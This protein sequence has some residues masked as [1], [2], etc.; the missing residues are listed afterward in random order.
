MT[1]NWIKCTWQNAKLEDN[2]N[3]NIWSLTEKSLKNKTKTKKPSKLKNE[4]TPTG[5]LS[6]NF[7]GSWLDICGLGLLGSC[8]A[9]SLLELYFISMERDSLYNSCL[10]LGGMHPAAEHLDLIYLLQW[11]SWDFLYWIIYINKWIQHRNHGICI[12]IKF[13]VVFRLQSLPKQTQLVRTH[14]RLD[15]QCFDIHNSINT[16][17]TSAY[18]K[19]HSCEVSL[20]SDQHFFLFPIENKI[21]NRIIP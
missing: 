2:N 3:W 4:L 8:K 1:L 6:E 16:F 12:K 18:P 17:C 13:N 20:Q 19:D 10:Y 14:C 11:F 9:L 21:P 15:I 5:L 7:Q